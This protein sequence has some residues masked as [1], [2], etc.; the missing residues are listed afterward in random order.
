MNG[1]NGYNNYNNNGYTPYNSYPGSPTPQQGGYPGY[2]HN[3]GQGYQQQ[4]FNARYYGGGSPYG[5]PVR[6]IIPN[7]KNNA[8]YYAIFLPLL[9]LFLES[10]AISKYLG[11]LLWALV[12]VFERIA[13]YGDAKALAAQN[14]C[15]ESMKTLAAI[16]PIVYVFRR[17][18]LF[19]RGVSQFVAFCITAALA[20]FQNGFVKSLYASPQTFIEMTKGRPVYSLSLEDDSRN[21]DTIGDKLDSYVNE[22]DWSYNR[23]KNKSTV[24]VTGVFSPDAPDGYKDKDV[25]FT[26]TYDFDGYNIKSVSLSLDKCELSGSELDDDE[27]KKLAKELFEQWDNKVSD[28]ESS[29]DAEQNDSDLKY[30]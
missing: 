10:F 9:A 24:I 21:T 30:A 4:G 16:A 18:Q 29:S 11:V 12:L 6:P 3:G 25:T 23:F 26:F 20:I 8:V 2:Q 14:R 5:A 17:N 27:C 28:D 22:Q 1:Y 13:V 19:S 15:P 7:L